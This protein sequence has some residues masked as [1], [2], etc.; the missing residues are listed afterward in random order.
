VS[1]CP[2]GLR[3][4]RCRKCGADLF[5]SGKRLVWFCAGGCERA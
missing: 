5:Y 4:P 1:G 3:L 2:Q